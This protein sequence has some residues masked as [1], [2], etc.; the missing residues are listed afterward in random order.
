MSDRKPGGGYYCD[1]S[2][3]FRW[4]VDWGLD[5]L[6]S[7]LRRTVPAQ[8]GIT[9]DKIDVVKGLKVAGTGRSG[10]VIVTVRADERY[11]EAWTVLNRHGAYNRTSPLP[12]AT[13][14]RS[15]AGEVIKAGDEVGIPIREEQV[16]VE[17][18]PPAR[19]EERAGKLP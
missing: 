13:A 17:K 8:L 9:A 3:R 5:T 18:G 19:E 16:R 7:I 15:E 10:R 2:P 12:S 14:Q 6:T 4:K 11:N 1:I